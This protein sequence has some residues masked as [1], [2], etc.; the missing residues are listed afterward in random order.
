MDRLSV[1]PRGFL[2]EGEAI[3]VARGELDDS[4]G[5][6]TLVCMVVVAGYALCD[7][8]AV[9]DVDC[10]V[11]AFEFLPE[12]VK[13]VGFLEGHAGEAVAVG[14]DDDGIL[15]RDESCLD[16]DGRG[17]GGGRGGVGR[18]RFVGRRGAEEGGGGWL[19]VGELLG[20]LAEEDGV[21]GELA[22]V[23]LRLSSVGGGGVAGSRG[24][25]F[26]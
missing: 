19:L 18:G 14:C 16:G 22:G 26:W 7:V 21:V 1:P 6:V 17:G 2:L 12:D 25:R 4:V 23:L 8:V 20:L 9:F 13:L 15:W 11:L 5:L 10:L 3:L 24:W